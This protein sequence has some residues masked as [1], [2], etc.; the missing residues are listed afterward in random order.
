MVKKRPEPERRGPRKTTVSIKSG[1]EWSEW[2]T[3][4]AEALHTT[5]AGLID[6]ALN[7]LA[8]REKIEPPPPR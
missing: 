4:A 3:R 5:R 8:R 7:E 1:G 2:L 6:R